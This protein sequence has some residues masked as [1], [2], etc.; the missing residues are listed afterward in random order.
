MRATL[1]PRGSRT[2]DPKPDYLPPVLCVPAISSREEKTQMRYPHGWSLK[3]S[4]GIRCEVAS[5]A[6]SS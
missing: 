6:L 4:P 2:A 3:R 1:I 5:R